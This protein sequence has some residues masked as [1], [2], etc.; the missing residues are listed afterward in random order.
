VPPA[1]WKI[2]TNTESHENC[3]VYKVAPKAL[4]RA[5]SGGMRHFFI[6]KSLPLKVLTIATI[7]PS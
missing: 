1:P 4:P 2:R 5:T 7:N 6:F 3:W